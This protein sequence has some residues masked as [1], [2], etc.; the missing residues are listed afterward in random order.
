VQRKAFWLIFIAL[1][2]IADFALPLLWGLLA[3]LPLIVLS[4][5]IAYRSGWFE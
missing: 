4:W 2:L 5:W 1:S 3:T